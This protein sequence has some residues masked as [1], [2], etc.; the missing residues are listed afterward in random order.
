MQLL[1]CSCQPGSL[2]LSRP[3]VNIGRLS[4]HIH[5]FGTAVPSEGD[6]CCQDEPP[7]LRS[8]LHVMPLSIQGVASASHSSK[9][10]GAMEELGLHTLLAAKCV[11]PKL[12]PVVKGHWSERT[13][14]LPRSP[15]P[16]CHPSP[17]G[18]S[19]TAAPHPSCRPYP[20]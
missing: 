20:A 3:K 5:P 13:G 10:L 9:S 11:R 17:C 15:R 12:Q 4:I 18:H 2:S 6:A 8:H 1:V 14:H 16:P 7:G 19:C